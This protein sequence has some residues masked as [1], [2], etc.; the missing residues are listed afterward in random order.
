MRKNFLRKLS[1]SWIVITGE[2]IDKIDCRNASGPL[3]ATCRV[4]LLFWEALDKDDAVKVP[5]ESVQSCIQH[6]VDGEEE[7]YNEGEKTQGH[8]HKVGHGYA[9]GVADF[10]TVHNET[11][12]EEAARRQTGE[13]CQNYPILD[14]QSAARLSERGSLPL[15]EW[16][17]NK[18]YNAAMQITCVWGCVLTSQ[19]GMLTRSPWNSK[20]HLSQAVAR[21]AAA[22]WWMHRSCT[23]RRRPLHRHGAISGP[24]APLSS[25]APSL[26][27]RRQLW[28]G[29]VGTKKRVLMLTPCK[30][31]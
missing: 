20:L 6:Q 19:A 29:A 28:A 22:H 30:Y 25:F 14:K 4:N 7:D 9:V 27:H 26:P 13:K 10:R 5:P 17:K 31:V 18:P 12:D 23:Y 1:S 21:V 16:Q 15:Q 8:N 24:R 3:A 11:V 2:F